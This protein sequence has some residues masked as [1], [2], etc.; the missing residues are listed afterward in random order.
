[1]DITL[2]TFIP[3][4]WQKDMFGN[5]QYWHNSRKSGDSRNFVAA[6]TGGAGKTHAGAMIVSWLFAQGFK[7]AL[8]IS[9]SNIIAGYWQRDLEIH[10]IQATLWESDRDYYIAT[11]FVT[12][13]SMMALYPERFAKMVKAGTVLIFDECH[14]LADS[15]AWGDSARLV[16]KNARIRLL[17]TGTLFREDE[18][19]IPFVTY[20]DGQLVPNFVYSYGQALEDGFVPPV[21]F[22]ALD[23]EMT[24]ERDSDA[25]SSAFKHADTHMAAKLRTALDPE[26]NWLKSYIADAHKTLN[27]IR[28]QMPNAAA[29]INCID[30]DHAR[31][32]QR[33]IQRITHTNPVLAISDDTDSDN[34]IERFRDGEEQ[35]LVVVRKGGEG[36]DIPR[37]RVGVWASNITKQL[38]FL[39]FLW[40]LT[41]GNQDVYFY[42]PAH[43]Q[44]QSYVPTIREMR[45]H[46][47]APQAL[48]QPVFSSSGENF[49]GRAESTFTPVSSE[50]GAM[51]EFVIGGVRGE[52]PVKLLRQIAEATNKAMFNIAQDKEILD[53]HDYATEPIRLIAAMLPQF[54]PAPVA[55]ISIAERA[56]ERRSR[57]EE[58]LFRRQKEAWGRVLSQ[59]QAQSKI[60]KD[61]LF[62]ILS[63]PEKNFTYK[64]LAR[65]LACAEGSV[66]LGQLVDTGLV[67]K[68]NYNSLYTSNFEQHIQTN[69]PSMPNYDFMGDILNIIEGKR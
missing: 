16:G 49:N 50:A 58:L 68:L 42:L 37:F 44:L 53:A 60:M 27:S 34:K 2:K 18:A 57:H 14:H 64:N 47:I 66:R 3:R 25:Y 10:G 6:V 56:E 48:E 20:K 61:C 30:Q 19:P 9:P 26:G 1:M 33:L 35:W 65:M 38:S 54:S 23:G 15:K 24:W 63:E 12:T 22:R 8:V 39:Q 43:F 31:Q 41:R 52:D 55:S 29:I 11:N 7:N 5:F 67:R 45:L 51:Q 28:E 32:V 17:L 21:Y 46:V 13:Y 62:Y 40:R 59:V 69:Y 4:Q 36:L